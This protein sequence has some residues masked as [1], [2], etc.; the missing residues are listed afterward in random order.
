[1]ISNDCLVVRALVIVVERGAGAAS[2]TNAATA[3][4]AANS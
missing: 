2:V 3:T 4:G 1:V